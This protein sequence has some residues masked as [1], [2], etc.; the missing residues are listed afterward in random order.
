MHA[1]FCVEGFMR[2]FTQ[3]NSNIKTLNKNKTNKQSKNN[4]PTNKQKQKQQPTNQPTKSS[5]IYPS[6]FIDNIQLAFL[7]GGQIDTYYSSWQCGG[8]V[9]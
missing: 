9:F 7:K 5:F 4:Q 2:S 1:W 6:F 3:Q 8:D